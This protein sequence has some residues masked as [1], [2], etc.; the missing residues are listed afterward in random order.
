MA[1]GAAAGG[2]VRLQIGPADLTITVPSAATHRI[3]RYSATLGGILTLE[4]NSVESLRMDL[5]SATSNANRPL[6][7]PG[8]NAYTITKTGS[9]VL[10]ANTRMMFNEA[11]A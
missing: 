8:D 11:F 9:Y 6:A 5:L 10:T 3:L 2:S 7:S 4:E 1:A